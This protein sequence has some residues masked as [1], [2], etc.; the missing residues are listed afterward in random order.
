M[1][2]YLHFRLC[3]SQESILITD[4]AK[5]SLHNSEASVYLHAGMLVASYSLV[6]GPMGLLPPAPLVYIQLQSLD[7]L[8][9][10]LLGRLG[11]RLGAL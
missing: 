2:G 1:N 3:S 5:Y 6:K 7:M 8:T 10:F 4:T 9:P 11:Q